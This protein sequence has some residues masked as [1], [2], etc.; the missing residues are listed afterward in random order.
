MASAAK[1]IANA[2]TYIAMGLSGCLLLGF[3]FAG[4]HFWSLAKAHF[5]SAGGLPS[6]NALSV[7]QVAFAGVLDYSVVLAIIVDLYWSWIYVILAL[8]CAAMT[9]LGV[10]RA[11]LRVR[12]LLAS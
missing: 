3:G 1:S 9:S 11:W 7:L 10:R 4:L 2:M 12:S 8:C 5:E 6:W